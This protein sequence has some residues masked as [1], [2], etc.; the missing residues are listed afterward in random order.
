MP[1]HAFA[2]SWAPLTLAAPLSKVHSGCLP[3]CV[4]NATCRQSAKSAELEAGSQ[5]PLEFQHDGHGNELRRR[6]GDTAF[7]DER[8]RVELR[9]I[10][11]D[12]GALK[13]F[14]VDHAQ[15]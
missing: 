11:L 3:A 15:A 13:E 5:R 12:D 9:S 8:N 6:L 4:A 2:S 7:D 10:F 1:P 14:G